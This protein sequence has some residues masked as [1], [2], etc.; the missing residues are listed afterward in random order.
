MTESSEFLPPD[1]REALQRAA[2][3]ADPNERL[4]AIDEAVRLARQQCGELFQRPPDDDE[5]LCYPRG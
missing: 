2:A 5:G 3:V 4:R 1:A